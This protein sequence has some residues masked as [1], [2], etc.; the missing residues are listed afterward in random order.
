[1][2]KIKTQTS[3]YCDRRDFLFTTLILHVLNDRVP[4]KYGSNDINH[5]FP[6]ILYAVGSHYL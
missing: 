5:N 6:L 2:L 4:F 1:M 3:L